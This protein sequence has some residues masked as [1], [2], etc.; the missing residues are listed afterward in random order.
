MRTV[1][2]VQT[3][4]RFRY[5]VR[6]L[7]GDYARCAAGFAFTLLPLGLLR[8]A[9][10]VS[11]VLGGVGALFFVYFGRTIARTLTRIELDDRGIRAGAWLDAWIRWDELCLVRLHYYTTRGDRSGGWMQLELRGGKQ[12]IITDSNI[13]GFAEIASAAARAAVCRGLRIDERSLTNLRALGILA[14]AGLEPAA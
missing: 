5:P 1:R 10:G 4:R 9:A 7:A 11:W 6:A 12:K 13:G 8:P 14:G 2:T 3:L